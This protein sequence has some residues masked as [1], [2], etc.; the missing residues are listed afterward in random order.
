MSLLWA[1]RKWDITAPSWPGGR[2]RCPRPGTGLEPWLGTAWHPGGDPALLDLPFPLYT[3][4]GS[5]PPQAPPKPAEPTAPVGAVGLGS[6][7]WG[8]IL[9]PVASAMLI[10]TTLQPGSPRSLPA[11][12]CGSGRRPGSAEF[13]PRSIFCSSLPFPAAAGP[14]SPPPPPANPK[15]RCTAD[16]EGGVSGLQGAADS[17]DGS[18]LPNPWV[19]PAERWGN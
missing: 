11:K 13:Y 18:I 2:Q 19:F 15:P 10:Y 8:R 17:W 1:K 7:R 6:P 3:E 5:G 9:S 16:P 4:A 14:A 12:A